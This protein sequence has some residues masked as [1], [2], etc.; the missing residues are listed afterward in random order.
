MLYEVI[1]LLHAEKLSAIGR[2]SA[3][4]AHEFN[5]PLQG[6]M[7]I[8]KGV[9]KRSPLDQEDARLMDLALTECI[10]MRDLIKS[11]QEFNQ[12][13]T[14]SMALVDIHSTI[15]NLLLLGK[16]EYETRHIGI[17]KKYAED[18]SLVRA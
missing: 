2:L 14:G 18:S 12:P 7:N 15:D 9:R 8:I 10:R 16:K 13:S 6:I 4:I 5:N 11:L 1:T 17:K 3:S